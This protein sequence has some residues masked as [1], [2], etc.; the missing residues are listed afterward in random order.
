MTTVSH[1][2]PTVSRTHLE[3][4]VSTVSPPRR[5]GRGTHS[6]GHFEGEPCPGH[7]LTPTS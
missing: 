3:R 6:T 5:G 4:G 2:V 7:A 1:R